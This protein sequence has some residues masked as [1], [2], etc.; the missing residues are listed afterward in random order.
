MRLL[1]LPALAA[2]V[3]LTAC[4]A[5]TSGPGSTGPATAPTMAPPVAA[6]PPAD[7]PVT[8]VGM[9]I[10]KPG[11]PPELCLGPVRESWPPQCEGIPLT[12]WDWGQH[13]PEQET[14]PGAAATRWGSFAVSGTFDGA[15]L[16]V[17]DAVP[18][19]LY[20]TMAEPT[21]TP[22][23]P[24]DLTDDAWDA[25]LE[26]VRSVPGLLGADRADGGPVLLSVVHDDGTIQ[27]WAD[28]SFGAGA[29][30]VSSALR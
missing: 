21:P 28:A 19:A 23:T 4:G 8:G 7:G 10:E 11:T 3:L 30:L 13:P 16:T 12:G 25:V 18:L 27:A 24:P 15:S 1:S 20:D 14:E 26:G 9:V 22:P 5:P 2:V 17:S 6:V 29:V